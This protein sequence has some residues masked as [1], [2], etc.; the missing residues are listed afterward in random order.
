MERKGDSA[1]RETAN[2]PPRVVRF[3]IMDPVLLSAAAVII[4]FLSYLSAVDSNQN[5]ARGAELAAV[6]TRCKDFSNG[7]FG[8][9]RGNL[10]D[11]RMYAKE[12]NTRQDQQ[13]EWN[14]KAII[15]VSK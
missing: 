3:R 12:I 7:Q 1:N 10:D 4:G 9:I 8:S 6:E 5:A 2:D 14:R 11:F 15:Q 13:I